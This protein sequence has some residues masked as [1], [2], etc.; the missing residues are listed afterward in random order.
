MT[1]RGEGADSLAQQHLLQQQQQQLQ[2]QRQ[3]LGTARS[4]LTSPNT[5]ARP[6][7]RAVSLGQRQQRLQQSVLERVA[8]D[9]ERECCIVE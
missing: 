6:V 8:T 5:R 1:G 2:Q 9:H 4:S 3:Q 7:S